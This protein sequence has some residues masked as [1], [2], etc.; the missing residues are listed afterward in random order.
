MSIRAKQQMSFEF[1]S[2]G[3]TGAEETNTQINKVVNVRSCTVLPITYK[4]DEKKKT[5]NLEITR[6]VLSRINHLL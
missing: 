1:G 5:E 3:N 2:G 6:G 4:S